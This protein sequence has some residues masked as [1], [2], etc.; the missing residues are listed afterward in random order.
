MGSGKQPWSSFAQYCLNVAVCCYGESQ[1]KQVSSLVPG[2]SNKQCRE[3]WVSSA[4]PG[5]KHDPWT[6]TEVR[7]LLELYAQYG[8]AWATIERQMGGRSQN[9]LKT[10]CSNARRTY[11][12]RGGTGRSKV[13]TIS[14]TALTLESEPSHL[15]AAVIRILAG[16]KIIE[17]DRVR[18]TAAPSDSSKAPSTDEDAASSS[19]C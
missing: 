6:L 16:K 9:S 12:R 1:W 5:L 7:A 15:T 18:D 13:G 11:N 10:F 4:R 14:S 17:I 8:P 2:K 19:S 3:R